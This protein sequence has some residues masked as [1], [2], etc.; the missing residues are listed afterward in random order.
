MF[1]E[2]KFKIV[3]RFQDAGHIVGM[4]G[5]GVNDAPAL[6][7]ADVGIAMKCSI[8]NHKETNGQ[9]AI[10]VNPVIPNE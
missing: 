2:H 1:P 7:Q 8:E 3:R 6:K 4:T 9:A 10:S 5:D